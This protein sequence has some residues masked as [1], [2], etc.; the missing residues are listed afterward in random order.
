MRVFISLLLVFVLS[1]VVLSQPIQQQEQQ[2]YQQES[3]PKFGFGL[4]FGTVVINGVTYF[5]VK[6]QPDFA[7]GKFGVGLDINLE[8]DA[9]WNIRATEW[10]SWQAI[11]SKI[12]YLRWA[13]KGEKPVYF[14][15]GQI[16]DG[17]IGNGFIMNNYDNNVN[18]PNIKKFGIAFDIDLD[19]GGIETFVDNIFDFDIIGL[20]PFARPLYGTQIPVLDGFEIGGSVVMDL[21]PLNPIPPKDYPY[22]FSDSPNSTNRVFIF[23]VDVGLPL[24]QLQPVFNMEWYADFAYILGKGTGEATGLKGSILSFIPYNLELRI[25]QPKFLPSFFDSLY[26]A[27]RYIIIGNTYLTK[28]DLLDGITNGYFGW[29]F[30]SGVS[31]EKIATFLVTLEDSFDDTTYPRMRITLNIDREL[32]KIVAFSLVYDRKNIDE[33][34][35]IYT[36]ESVDAILLTKISYKVSDMVSIVLSYRRTFD[37]FEEGGQKVLKPLE[38]TSVSTEISF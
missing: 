4:S 18:Y 16:D 24:I 26:D 38:S 25:L 9:N 12:R 23:G 14:K 7:I 32:T 30:T 15:I 17:R 13:Q 10:N 36:T 8:F 19:Y 21:D 29:L 31:F 27:E 34:R 37:W 28:Y 22:Q 1:G 33:F 20:R 5:Q 6:G 3:A 11:L 2:G 35:D